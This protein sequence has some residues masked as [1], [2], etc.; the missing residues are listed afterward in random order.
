MNFQTRRQTDRQAGRG[1]RVLQVT[2]SAACTDNAEGNNTDGPVPLVLNSN[3]DVATAK[4]G[5]SKQAA[6]SVCGERSWERKSGVGMK[7]AKRVVLISASPCTLGDL[8]WQRLNNM[9]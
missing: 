7:A 5:R 4:A 6:Y 2:L 1:E 3:V 8:I 9:L